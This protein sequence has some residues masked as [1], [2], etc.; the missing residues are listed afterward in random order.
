[1]KIRL[2]RPS[3][4]LALMVLTVIVTV[5]R[6]ASVPAATTAI[7][8]STEFR[9]HRAREAQL[10]IL[11]WMSNARVPAAGVPRPA[12]SAIHAG[13]G[14]SVNVDGVNF[15]EHRYLTDNGNQF[16]LEPPDPGDLCRERP[17]H[18]GG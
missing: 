15:F 12:S 3:L 4:G 10:L 11:N 9:P 14:A 1:M 7:D 6:V 17:R 16:S 5:G 8:I 2:S 18:L 13:T